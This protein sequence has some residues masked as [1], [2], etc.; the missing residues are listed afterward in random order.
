MGTKE[1]VPNLFGKEHQCRCSADDCWQVRGGSIFTGAVNI[2]TSHG[3]NVGNAVSASHC[4]GNT[5]ATES[6]ESM[7]YVGRKAPDLPCYGFGSLRLKGK[8]GNLAPKLS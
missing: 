8:Y 4:P 7:H 5:T 3:Y 2:R 1:T 6:M